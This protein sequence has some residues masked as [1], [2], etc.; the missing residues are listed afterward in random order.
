MG[1]TGARTMSSL[2]QLLTTQEPFGRLAH[3]LSGAQ[4]AREAALAILQ[5][6]DEMFGWDA[7]HLNLYERERDRTLSIV[8]IDT[9]DGVKQDF[10]PPPVSTPISAMS[11]RVLK[12]GAQLI[13]FDDELQSDFHVPRLV[14]FGSQ[15]KSRS[16]MYVPIRKGD[17]S[18]GVLS[19]QTYV[20]TAYNREDLEAL[21]VL[22]DYCAGAMERTL[23]EERLRRQSFLAQRFA[24]LGKSLSEAVTPEGAAH[25]IFDTARDLFGWDAVF[26]AVISE[27]DES[28]RWQMG[29]DTVG[30]ENVPVKMSQLTRSLSPMMRKVFRDGAQLILREE[31][32]ESEGGRSF[33]RF[34]DLNRESKSLLFA[35]LRSANACLGVLSVQSYRVDAYSEET[36]ETLQALADHC[37]G[38]MARTFAEIDLRKFQVAIEQDP[39][40]VAILDHRHHVEYV[41]PAFERLTGWRRDELLNGKRV[42]RVSGVESRERLKELRRCMAAGENF[43]DV[44]TMRRKSGEIYHERKEVRPLR[45]AFGVVT[46]YVETG[47]D[48]TAELKA[49]DELRIAYE[50][51][52]ARVHE[53]TKELS[54]SNRQ[55]QREVTVRASVEADLEKSLALFRATVESS[56]GGLV[57]VDLAGRIVTSNQQWL[58]L[59]GI[60]ED[61]PAH[62]RWKAFLEYVKPLLKEPGHLKFLQ[63]KQRNGLVAEGVRT[64]ELTDGRVLEC[65]FRPQLLGGR[66]V[67]RVWNFRDTTRQRRTEE[68][69]ARSEQIYRKAIENTTGVPYQVRYDSGTYEFMGDGVK[70]LL[71]LETITPG[72]IG[73]L[74]QEYVIID[75]EIHVDIDEYHRMMRLGLLDKYRVDFRILTPQGEEKWVSDSAVPLKDEKSGI[76]YG[77]LGILQDI[78]ARKGAEEQTRLQQERLVQTE[79]L[80]ALGTLV[81]GVAHEINNPNN[82]IM[83]NAPILL[84]AWKGIQ[85]ILSEYYKDNG[86]FVVAGLNYSELVDHLPALCTGILSGS[87]RINSIVQELRDFA[88]PN[89]LTYSETV[90]VNQVVRSA[91]ILLHIIIENSTDHFT[92][93]LGENIPFVF[94]NSLRLEQVVI[95]LIQNACQ[96]LR[97][98]EDAVCVATSYDHEANQVIIAVS[99]EGRGIAPEH[100]KRITDPFFTTRRDSG[101]IGLGLSI[102]SNIVHH[103]GGTLEF[104]SQATRG[105]TVRVKVPAPAPSGIGPAGMGEGTYR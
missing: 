10:P 100:L 83:L 37:S 76:P 41:N 104:S 7:C 99:D 47:T 86:D 46:H 15:R 6:A 2:K 89:P 60:A 69:Q 54:Q 30:G 72:S 90:D 98:K 13:F 61:Q 81:S 36:L 32:E 50:E 102:S 17:E 75:P 84:E 55:L 52:E 33:Q 63:T 43:N 59:W 19:I 64:I 73:K 5:L 29:M 48:I 1:R 70:A 57:A 4:T 80:V 38:A 91:L 40:S 9:L 77:S 44:L 34:G 74:I 56:P 53:R 22:A 31:D 95:N 97:S 14:G 105:T 49:G 39:S 3:T 45:N 82:F 27:K 12:E 21:Q 28:I 26:L 92:L 101:G 78:T 67:G 71:G 24:A 16:L 25:V 88:R 66:S 20:A 35:P 103:H 79:K 51:L 23:A 58:D 93:E 96:S 62:R 42:F 68:A 11:R 85:P 87:Q 94:G 8:N 65:Q 18:F